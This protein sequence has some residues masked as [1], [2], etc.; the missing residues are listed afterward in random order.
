MADQKTTELAALT[1]PVLADLLQIVDDPA[2][3]PVTKQITIAD[4]LTLFV[5]NVTVQVLT[6]SSGTY[7][8]TARMKKVLLIVVGAGGPS[9]GIT[10]AVAVSGGG[11]GGGTVI[12]LLTAADIGASQAYTVGQGTAAGQNTTIAGLIAGGGG[13]SAQI[14]TSTIGNSASGG[15]CGANTGGDLSIAG[16]AGGRG[17]TYSATQ[18]RGGRGGSSVFG[19]GGA[20]QGSEATGVVGQNYGGGASGSHT[21]TN[22][23]RGPVNGAPGV[24]YAIEFLG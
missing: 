18:A 9:L 24:I 3:S 15:V 11:S 17:L 20:E 4:L 21:A 5:S 16:E 23:D 10:A 6:A 1:T 7:T 8:P 2:G 12:K 22:V 14:T 19:M 13:I